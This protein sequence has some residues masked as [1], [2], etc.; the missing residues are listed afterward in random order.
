MTRAGCPFLSPRSPPRSASRSAPAH[1]ARN[2]P[3][4]GAPGS[5]PRST[6][7]RDARRRARATITYLHGV[8]PG[9]TACRRERAPA[10]L[11]AGRRNGARNSPTPIGTVYRSLRPRC[12][13]SWVRG[14]GHITTQQKRRGKVSPRAPSPSRDDTAASASSSIEWRRQRVLPCVGLANTRSRGQ[15]P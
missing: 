13:S 2:H 14:G 10:N 9:T 12:W 11:Q 15:A 3:D 5:A 6:R 8:V 7:P 4:L 1:D